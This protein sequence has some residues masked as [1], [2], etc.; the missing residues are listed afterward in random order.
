MPYVPT[1]N[2]TVTPGKEAETSAQQNGDVIAAAQEESQEQSLYNGLTGFITLAKVVSVLPVTGVYRIAAGKSLLNSYAIAMQTGN[3]RIY[4]QKDIPLYAPGTDVLVFIVGEESDDILPN[5][6]LGAVNP[7]AL[8]SDK[9]HLFNKYAELVSRSGVEAANRVDQHDQLLGEDGEAMVTRDYSY[10]RP[11]DVLPGEWARINALNG[12]FFLSDF[13]AFMKASD[14]AKVECFLFDNSVKLMWEKF[15]SQNAA[16]DERVFYDRFGISR[17]RC[18]ASTLSEGLGALGGKVALEDKTFSDPI[19]KQSRIWQ[20]EANQRGLFTQNILEGYLVDGTYEFII[21][22]P[23]GDSAY[24]NDGKIAPGLMSV[25]KRLDGTFKV[26]AAKEISLEKTMYIISPKELAD[27]DKQDNSEEESFE[28]TPWTDKHDELEKSSFLGKQVLDDYDEHDNTK[29]AFAGLHSKNKYWKLQGTK[30][31]VY[32]AFNKATGASFKPEFTLD[33]LDDTKPHYEEP[34]RKATV[35]PFADADGDR[36]DPVEVF[37]ISTA[38]RQI[39]DGSIVLTG[40]HGEEIRMYKGNIYLSCPGDIIEQPG[41]DKVTFAPRHLIQKADKG[42]AELTSN[43]SVNIAAAG[44]VQMTAAASGQKGTMVIE[45]KSKTDLNTEAFDFNGSLNNNEGDWG[46]IVIKSASMLA[47]MSNHNF[48]GYNGSKYENSITQINSAR[49]LTNAKNAVTNIERSGTFSI[50]HLGGTT[51]TMGSSI[52]EVLTKNCNI[53]CNN[54]EMTKAVTDFNAVDYKGEDISVSIA[55]GP[56]NLAV[57]G[58]GVFRSLSAVSG[59]I[60]S[61]GTVS[62]EVGGQGPS[63]PIGSKNFG[64]ISTEVGQAS[65]NAFA[66]QSIFSI[67]KD[68]V[69]GSLENLKKISTVMPSMEAYSTENFYMPINTWQSILEGT[70]K[71]T[72]MEIPSEDQSTMS[73]PGK[74]RWNSGVGLKAYEEGRVAEKDIKTEYVINTAMNKTGV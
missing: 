67:F 19:S 47:I 54:V 26:K 39:E 62:G 28:R 31:E 53:G 13:V 32:T 7:I 56:A 38:I 10:G 57:K 17:I 11:L 49:V 14:M 12:G 2:A 48:I 42:S 35:F 50:V 3:N 25:E 61:L 33:P 27:S 59:A 22:P 16:Y 29:N 40:G 52:F 44:N 64:S 15:S 58:A 23:I 20:V 4:G 65:D 37:D 68:A 21:I 41:R 69:E 63:A 46:G 9:E 6:I 24:S 18:L 72:E 36:F 5:I 73:F 60:D 43:N 1:I 8:E 51:L 71:W 45:N 66:Q 74:E 30:E 34:P 70:Q 55:A